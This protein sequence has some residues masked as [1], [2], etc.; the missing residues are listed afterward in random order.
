MVEL[1]PATDLAGARPVSRRRLE[2]LARLSPARAVHAAVAAQALLLGGLAILRHVSF[3]SGRFDLGNMTQAVWST[4]HG[5]PLETTAMGGEQFVRLGAHFDPLLAVFAAPWVVVPSPLMLVGVQAVALALGA[6]PV[7]W[8]ARK[9]LASESVAARFAVAYLLFPAV[10]WNAHADFHPVSLAIPLL[11]FAIWYLDEDRLVPFALCAC[12]AGLTKEHVPLLI[13]CLGIWYAVARGQRPAGLTVA[14]LGTAWFAAASFVLVPHF[15]PEGATLFDERFGG[16][17]NG[18][19]EVLATIATNPS[20]LTSVVGW[21]DARYL[22][23]LLLPLLGLWARAPLLAACA[24]P[25]VGLD[26]LSAKA[27]QTSIMFHYSSGIVP[28]VVAAS[29]LGAARLDPER[30][31]RRARLLVQVGAAFLVFSPL[32][33]GPSYARSLLSPEREA[34]QAAVALVPRAAPVSSTNF[35]G[36]HL[37][38]RERVFSFPVLAGAEWVVVDTADPTVGDRRDE[39]AFASR[40]AALDRNRAWR[41]VFDRDGVRLYRRVG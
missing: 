38:E 33:F 2:T 32:L 3:H 26:V 36:A 28:F 39:E 41:R 35:L 27:E 30:L 6:L 9:H 20:A 5:R 10:L 1:A 13:A 14:A 11:L 23:L 12:A 16:L 22:A 21:S 17:G 24:L 29:V 15:A 37:S 40:L 25:Q 19:G 4:T 18:P 7:F 8:L 31:R 34:R